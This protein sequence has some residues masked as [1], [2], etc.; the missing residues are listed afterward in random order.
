MSRATILFSGPDRPG[1]VA[2]LS[3]FFYE[4]GLNI[5]EAS[6]FTDLHSERGA[7]AEQSESEENSE[8]DE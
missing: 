7:R 2:R 1:L 5:L 4:L 8:W 3:G 6:N